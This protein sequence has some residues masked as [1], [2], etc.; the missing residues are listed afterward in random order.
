VPATEAEMVKY[1]GNTYLAARVIFANQMYDL[2]Q[3]IGVDYDQVRECVGEDGRIG[4]SH[5][6]IWQG[7]YRGYGAKCF[8]KDIRALIQLAEERG[9]DFRLHKLIEEINRELAESQQI[10]DME[11]MRP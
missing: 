2:C 5:F 11:K 4:H 6:D 3:A 9:V 1:F 8:P 10:D 7:G